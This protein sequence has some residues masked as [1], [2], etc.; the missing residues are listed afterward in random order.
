LALQVERFQAVVA[1]GERDFA[2]VTEIMFDDVPM[3]DY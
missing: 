2:A 1:E 3:A